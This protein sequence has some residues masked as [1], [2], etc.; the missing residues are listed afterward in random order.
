MASHENI[1]K[2]MKR[3][4][5]KLKFQNV[6]SSTIQMHA[7]IQINKRFNPSKKLAMKK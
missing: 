1:G 7:S 2:F 3:T 5:K 4:P 6:I